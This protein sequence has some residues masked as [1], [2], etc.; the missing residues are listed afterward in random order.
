MMSRQSPKWIT[1]VIYRQGKIILEQE[2]SP[3]FL[4]IHHS[5]TKGT[6]AAGIRNTRE[7]HGSTERPLNR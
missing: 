2:W 3:E 1:L 5:E 4:P 6:T 7:V